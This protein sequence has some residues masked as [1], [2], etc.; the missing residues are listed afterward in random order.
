MNFKLLVG[1]VAISAAV[2]LSGCDK[3]KSMMGGEAEQKAEEAK[4][5]EEEAK[6]V[7]EDAKA[8]EA[9]SAKKAEEATK[10]AEAA[11]KSEEEAK[12]TAE[13]AAKKAEAEK[14]VAEEAA[15]KAEEERLKAE[16]EKKKA[17]EEKAAAE[18]TAKREALVKDLTDLTAKLAQ[19]KADLTT[20]SAAWANSGDQAKSAELTALLNEVNTLY[21]EPEAVQGLMAQSKLDEAR[22]KLD[23]L[24]AKLQPIADKASPLVEEKP[25]DPA[26]FDK[27]LNLLAEETC[28]IKKNL[29]TQDFQVAREAL[30]SKYAMDRVIYEQLRARYNQNPKPEDQS[31]LGQYVAQYCP[32]PPAA[33]QPA[34]EQPAG[35]QPA[36][37]KPAGEQPATTDVKKEEAK[38]SALDGVYK[39]TVK[40][41]GKKPGKLDVIVKNGKLSSATLYFDNQIFNLQGVF[42]THLAVVGKSKGGADHMKCNGTVKGNAVVGQCVGT[43]KKEKFEGPFD[44]K[45]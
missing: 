43:I 41:K 25:V 34:A 38:T 19:L 31:K 32:E 20:S 18:E 29:P 39:G 5:A 40:G 26:M 7:A 2:A 37:E 27:M 30:F 22:T 3:V 35:E 44:I 17:E 13:E 1:C 45:K 8:K 23:V 16:E 10:Q 28:L 14:K 4:K 11:K 12:K 15:K 42:G 21:T 9:E 24:K 36:A 6:K 33:E